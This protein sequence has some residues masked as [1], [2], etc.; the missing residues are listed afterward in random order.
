MR[1]TNQ[2]YQLVTSSDALR[3]MIKNTCLTVREFV[4]LA[5][6]HLS[7]QGSEAVN[8]LGPLEEHLP[9]AAVNEVLFY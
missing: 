2:L 9:P 6:S 4:T 8:R 3:Q 7:G 5:Y 1:E